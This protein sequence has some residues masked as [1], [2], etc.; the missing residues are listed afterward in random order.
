[1]E[2]EYTDFRPQ[3]N[4]YSAISC[5]FHVRLWRSFVMS[6]MCLCSFDS[7][8]HRKSSRMCVKRMESG[9][10]SARLYLFCRFDAQLKQ[11]LFF[12]AFFC[13]VL[14]VPRMRRMNV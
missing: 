5:L 14:T 3:N 7:T 13:F 1:M 12:A 9:M 6:V 10:V 4:V 2:Y 11:C 8:A